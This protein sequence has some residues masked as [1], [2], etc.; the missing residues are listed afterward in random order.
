MFEKFSAYILSNGSGDYYPDN[1]LSAFSVKFPFSLELPT[2]RN[3]KWLIAL[4]SIGLSSKFESEYLRYNNDPLILQMVN[5]TDE[6]HCY[7]ET[8]GISRRGCQTRILE[9]N[10]HIFE[11]FNKCYYG[12]EKMKKC[13]SPEIKNFLVDWAV[14]NLHT[15]SNFK[16]GDSDP[17]ATIHQLIY[18]YHSL[19]DVGD[20]NLLLRNLKESQLV[21]DEISKTKFQITSKY[22][23]ERLFFIRTDLVDRCQVSQQF[24][25]PISGQPNK[26]PILFPSAVSA[27]NLNNSTIHIGVHNYKMFVLNHEFTTL[28]LEFK[29][30]MGGYLAIPNV[31]KIK[32]DSI[33]YQVFNNSYSNDLEVMKPVF[34]ENDMHYFHEF[35]KPIFIPLLTSTLSD[36]K[37]ELTDEYNERLH[38]TAGLPTVL[39]V[40]LKKMS[41][42]YKSFNVR[43]TPTNDSLDNTSSK[44]VTVLPN[45]FT[46]T[47]K[48]RVGLKDVVF[49][50]HFKNLPSNENE[51][52]I[53][54]LEPD[55]TVIH[56]ERHKIHI[57]N[58][59][60]SLREFINYL[61]LKI[62]SVDAIILETDSTT[63]KVIIKPK[64]CC[65]ISISKHLAQLLGFLP[66]IGESTTANYWKH[67]FT[68]FSSDVMKQSDFFVNMELFR[69]AYL[70]VYLDFI[71]QTLV[72]GKY[73]NILK[74]VPVKKEKK[75]IECQT[76]EFRTVEFRKLAKLRLSEITAEIRDPS[77]KLIQFDN[78]KLALHLVF[79]NNV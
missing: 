43:L 66:M 46:F 35:E 45:T 65:H 56:N 53:I 67:T 10:K 27:R 71:E 77:G 78:N 69:P 17:S 25:V 9:H 41:S 36:L 22:D 72:S 38:L 34:E 54:K 31:I 62:R 21:I 18:Y 57:P 42:T 1:T 49:P 24:E 73:T 74:F 75:E 40:T 3:E 8:S 60:G 79:S 61:N 58:I 52:V 64:T 2:S 14:K 4:N 16:G 5:L 11:L 39:S 51:I 59:R 68:A 23:V 76:L 32:C 7:K 26:P 13:N 44:F 19:A 28:N 29:G 55:L 12:D 50:N 30:F 63:N 48:W 37:F 70:L 20:L 33:R 47:N 6:S 15:S